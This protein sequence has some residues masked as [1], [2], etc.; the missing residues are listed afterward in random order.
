MLFLWPK[1]WPGD[2]AKEIPPG[3]LLFSDLRLRPPGTQSGAAPLP[4]HRTVPLHPAFVSLAL[5]NFLS[6][7]KNTP[8]PFCIRILRAAQFPTTLILLHTQSE[9]EVSRK[10]AGDNLPPGWLQGLNFSFP[11]RYVPNKAPGRGLRQWVKSSLILW[12][13]KASYPSFSSA[14]YLLCKKHRWAARANFLK[15]H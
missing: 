4:T 1:I 13:M 10:W 12:A 6:G 15:G 9:N 11:P 14:A 5:S 2:V 3:S 8:P 7:V